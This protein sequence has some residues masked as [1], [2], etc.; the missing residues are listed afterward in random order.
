MCRHPRGQRHEAPDVLTVTR[1]L[2]STELL[3]LSRNF[4][5]PSRLGTGSSSGEP[6]FNSQHPQ[7]SSQLSATLVSEDLG[8]SLLASAHTWCTDRHADKISTLFFFFNAVAQASIHDPRA[9]V[10]NGGQRQETIQNL[11]DQLSWLIHQQKDCLKWWIRGCP[12]ISTCASE[13]AHTPPHTMYHT[14][15]PHIFPKTHTPICL[16]YTHT[17]NYCTRTLIPKCQLQ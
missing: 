6:E 1:Q 3:L 17:I 8:C 15:S 2:S 9:P 11:T 14:H 12:L 13:H 7:D 4:T 5:L 16:P 10:R